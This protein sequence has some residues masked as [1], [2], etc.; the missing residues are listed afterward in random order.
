MPGKKRVERGDDKENIW[1][2]HQIGIY[3]PKGSRKRR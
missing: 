2:K 1:T 3:D